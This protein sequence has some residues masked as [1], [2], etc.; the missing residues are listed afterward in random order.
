MTDF[1]TVMHFIRMRDQ[2][3]TQERF[4]II[5]EFRKETSSLLSLP[6]KQLEHPLHPLE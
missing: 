3:T 2:F 1:K 4:T 5:N 6:T